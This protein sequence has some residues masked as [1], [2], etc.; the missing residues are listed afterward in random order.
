[1]M[2]DT[3]LTVVK[4]CYYDFKDYIFLNIPKKVQ[5]IN[6]CEVT[7]EYLTDE[8]KLK[9]TSDEKRRLI[10]KRK[11]E[12][13]FFVDLVKTKD[14]EFGFS[15][16]PKNFVRMIKNL[17][18]KPFEDLGKI[19]DLEPKILSDLYKAIKNEAFIKAPIKPTQ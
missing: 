11:T 12:P 1:M 6:A 7:N 10:K 17:F 13:L 8:E 16:N 15:V 3:V 4:K 19:P 18:E 9:L 2:E 14:D 5:V